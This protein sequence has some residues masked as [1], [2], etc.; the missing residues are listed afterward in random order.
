M[1]D[2]LT[3]NKVKDKN[4]C[5]GMAYFLHTSKGIKMYWS[6]V[7][8]CRWNCLTHELIEARISEFILQFC[9]LPFKKGEE[10]N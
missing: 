8:S 5:L 9:L 3:A 1:L 6:L 4:R 2:E 7:F 10:K